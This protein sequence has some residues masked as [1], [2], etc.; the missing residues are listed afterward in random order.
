MLKR[1]L[2]AAAILALTASLSPVLAQEDL[3]D[4]AEFDPF[5]VDLLTGGVNNPPPC[6]TGTETLEPLPDGEEGFTIADTFLEV[7]PVD[8]C[9]SYV[10]PLR[11]GVPYK[12]IYVE[13]DMY[14]H[15]WVT[16]IFHNVFA[17]RRTSQ[18]RNERILYNGV[19]IRGDNRRTL[20]D[21]GQEK[22]IKSFHPWKQET[23]YHVVIETNL[24][25]KRIKLDVFEGETWSHGAQGKITARELKSYGGERVVKIDFSSSAIAFSGYFP[26]TGW[27]FANLKVTAIP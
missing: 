9:R 3:F 23:L 22:M 17:L 1:A 7:Q 6:P 26:P 19:V 5:D 18:K 13:F 14:L 11:E 15:R 16:P 4:Q 21:L 2:L 24:P 25:A 8:L 20:L 27:R 12:A 10:V